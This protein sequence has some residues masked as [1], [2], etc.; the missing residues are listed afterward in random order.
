[1]LYTNSV[2]IH[3]HHHISENWGRY[4]RIGEGGGTPHAEQQRLCTTQRSPAHY[5]QWG[6]SW[7]AGPGSWTADGSSSVTDGL[8]RGGI[9]QGIAA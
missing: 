2:C 8:P 4:Q 3:H 9:E 7:T 5:L 6:A 1:M